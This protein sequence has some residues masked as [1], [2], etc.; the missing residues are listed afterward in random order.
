MN[1]RNIALLTGHIGTSPQTRTTANGSQTTRFRLATHHRYKTPTGE[2]KE[3]TDWHTINAWGRT[4]AFCEKT[5]QTGDSVQVIG[6]I[7]NDVVNQS[8]VK[9][10]FTSIRAWEINLLSRHADYSESRKRPFHPP[11]RAHAPAPEK[12]SQNL[13]HEDSLPF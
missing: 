10:F 3:R 9:K 5:L 11:E 7:C 13:T 2:Q 8:G 12:R 1:G 4:A 6:T